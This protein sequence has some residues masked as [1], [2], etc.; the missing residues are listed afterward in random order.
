MSYNAIAQLNYT[1]DFA[2]PLCSTTLHHALPSS[3]W[4]QF[5]CR[6]S[7]IERLFFHLF[8]GP[9]LA[10]C[11]LACKPSPIVTK[12]LKQLGE[13]EH[14]LQLSR[15]SRKTHGGAPFRNLTPPSPS[16]A[17]EGSNTA[18]PSSRGPKW[19]LPRPCLDPAQ[20]QSRP[21]PD[22]AWT[23]PGPSLDP[24]WTRPGPLADR[25]CAF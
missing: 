22:P 9:W 15:P 5:D 23:R 21:S 10:A 20:I 24:V 16:G 14:N 2:A 13:S 6:V 11:R 3:L 18:W 19:I 4:V 12:Q 7:R 25:M 1:H 8:V 17:P